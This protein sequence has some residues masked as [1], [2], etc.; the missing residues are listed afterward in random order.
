MTPSL[1]Y[2]ILE[3]EPNP[4]LEDIQRQW[5]KLVLVHHPDRHVEASD[6]AR[7]DSAQKT[8]RLNQAYS[9]L[10]SLGRLRSTTGSAGSSEVASEESLRALFR[11]ARLHLER[12]ETA[13]EKWQRQLRQAR[14]EIFDQQRLHFDLRRQLKTLEDLATH[15]VKAE[16]EKQ[17]RLEKVLKLYVFTPENKMRTQSLNWRERSDEEILQ[18][19]LPKEPQQVAVLFAELQATHRD[20]RREIFARATAVE[21]ERKATANL[22]TRLQKGRMRLPSILKPFQASAEL[23]RQLVDSASESIIIAEKA[24]GKFEM[25]RERKD[26]VKNIQHGIMGLSQQL[27]NAEMSQVEADAAAF[28]YHDLQ[29]RWQHERGGFLT[30]RQNLDA[31]VEYLCDR[32][33]S[34]GVEPGE[35]QMRVLKEL[36]ERMRNL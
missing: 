19:C 35:F 4:S 30:L 29:T 34:A 2:R 32:L 16:K 33:H 36:P 18:S 11:T 7:E 13:I 6:D 17:V 28:V 23:A 12:A 21:R 1:A 24:A 9:L 3:L 27:K 14:T 5:R 25:A 20:Y 31:Q 15:Y 26:F 22:M 8:K 10:R